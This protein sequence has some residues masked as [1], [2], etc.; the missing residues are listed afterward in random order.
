MFSPSNQ[1]SDLCLEYEIQHVPLHLMSGTA[2][3]AQN[4]PPDALGHTHS[5]KGF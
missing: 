1:H 2:L 3:P 4:V 5:A